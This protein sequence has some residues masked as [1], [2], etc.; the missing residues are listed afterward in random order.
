MNGGTIDVSSHI[1]LSSNIKTICENIENHI[2]NANGTKY[3]YMFLLND[4]R[5]YRYNYRRLNPDIVNGDINITCINTGFNNDGIFELYVKIIYETSGSNDNIF[6][7][8]EMHIIYKLN[9]L[10][11]C[12]LN[13]NGHYLQYISNELRNDKEIALTAVSTNWRAL[14]YASD[15]LKNNKEFVL[16][17]ASQNGLALQYASG[18]LKHD[19]EI[20]LKAVSQNGLALQY[21]SNELKNDKEIILIAIS[22]NGLALRYASDELRND[23][24]NVKLAMSTARNT[25]CIR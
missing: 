8:N 22:Q 2:N 15:E 6:N 4:N 10:L 9:D 17:A 13:N 16:K 5:L 23:K 18:E 25:I 1:N 11:L 12:L 20:V 14:Q 21:A 7:E 19:I 24:E 3:Y